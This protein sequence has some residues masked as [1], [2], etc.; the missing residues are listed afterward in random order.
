MGSSF[1]TTGLNKSKSMP[2]S[3]SVRP[4]FANR[5]YL[6]IGKGTKI[7]LLDDD[8]VNIYE[9]SV[10]VQ[11]DKNAMKMKVTCTSPGKMPVPNSCRI[12]NAM[13]KD[14][15]ISRKF[16]AYLSAIDLSKFS[17]DG[18]EY[19]HT[20]K[21]IPLNNP[22]AK[23]LLRR[24]EEFG[25]LK[26]SIFKIFRN[27]KTSP[28]VGDDWVRIK[29]IKLAEFFAESPRVETIRAHYKKIGQN[30][31]KAE[32][33]KILIAPFDYAT[34]LEPT[35]QRVE[36]FLGYLGFGDAP[37]TKE[38]ESSTYDYS[39]DDEE[40]DSSDI[41]EE[42]FTE[43][44]DDDEPPVTPKKKKKKKKKAKKSKKASK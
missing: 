27:E 19:T 4:D 12:C 35:D 36:Y 6:P 30:I 34:E 16:V 11:G 5:L 18:K 26:G 25:P 32:A 1:M 24:K 7:V 17:I 20:R 28:V 29:R 22:A 15:R 39:D 38:P 2:G 10:W 42:D 37:T 33:V 40:D 21:L 23:T 44:E 8:S 3:T 43:F 13:I 41:K 31:S 14:E 9:H